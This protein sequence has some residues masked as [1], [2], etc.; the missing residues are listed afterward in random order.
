MHTLSYSVGKFLL[1]FTGAELMVLAMTLGVGPAALGASVRGAL[2]ASV[3]VVV[4][5]SSFRLVP[6]VSI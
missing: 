5:L 6:E 4:E 3:V 2:F 1:Y